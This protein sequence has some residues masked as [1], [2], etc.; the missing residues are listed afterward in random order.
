[1]TYWF[2]LDGMLELAEPTPEEL[3]A[4]GHDFSDRGSAEPFGMNVPDGA[5]E[6][7]AIN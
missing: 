1:M 3:K 2:W 6:D 7:G 4:P 5:G